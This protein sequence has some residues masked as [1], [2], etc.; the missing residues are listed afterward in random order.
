LNQRAILCICL[1]AALALPA[2]G[3]SQQASGAKPTAAQSGGLKLTV[4]QGEGAS[5]DI[6]RQAATAPVVE[7]RDENEKPVA[8]AEVV[9][10]VPAAGPSGVFYGWMRTQ[11]VRS[12]ERGRAVALG[13]RPNDEAGRFNIE[14]GAFAAGKRGTV[15]ITQ[16]NGSGGGTTAAAR[17]KKSRKALWWVVGAV[18]VGA[19]AGG[20]AATRGGSSTAATLPVPIT[21]ST[22]PVTVAG[23]R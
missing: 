4:I 7:V 2:P 17:D 19:I 21:V 5:N 10:T 6:S 20:V 22:G 18:A 11:T 12:D 13:F 1:A 14:V 23:P 16:T 15:Y 3:W 8:G 9:F